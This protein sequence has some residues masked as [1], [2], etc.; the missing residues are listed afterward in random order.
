MANQ[1]LQAQQD[2]ITGQVNNNL[3]RNVLPGIN[4]RAMAA[5]GFG[6]SR[7]GIAE[8]LGIGESSRA[9]ADATA[10]LQGNAY[11][12]DQQI[13]SQ[14]SMQQAQLAAQE[15]MASQSNDTQRLGINNQYSLG[16]G[17]LGLGYQTAGQNYELGKGN[18]GLG[19]QN[20]ANQYA[21]GMGNLGLG[22]KTADNSYSLGM[23]NL[24]LGYQ[25]SNN[26]Y[27]LGMGNLGLGYQTAGQNYELGK[28]NLGLGW[29]NS[30]N[31]YAL[32]SRAADT[33]QFQAQTS[34]DLG[35][36]QL[37]A[38]QDANDMSFYT[39]QRGQDLSAQNQGFNQWLSAF[40][41]QNGMGQQQYNIGQ[42]QQQAPWTAVQNYS[43]T[44]QPYTGLGGSSS[45]TDPGTGGGWAG[46]AGG[47]LTAAQLWA[48]MNKGG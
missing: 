43:N 15:R 34:R 32:G 8:G 36:G 33:N 48:L 18:L 31:Q 1:Y 4:R 7:Q 22:H 40:N 42:Q 29:Q 27:A 10:N 2:A 46:A 14:Q 12:Q 35:F 16:M 41:A 23:G 19:W 6:G 25:N 37:G 39:A 5:G 47:A 11:A 3:Q 45:R 21:L 20:S 26:Q 17:N 28:G 9:I 38:Q 44:L 30:A 13:A 24:G